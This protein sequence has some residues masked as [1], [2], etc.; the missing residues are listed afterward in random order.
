MSARLPGVVLLAIA[1]LYGW[2]AIQIPVFAADVR[3][4]MTAQTMPLVLA[5]ALAIIG[6]ILLFP[7]RPGVLLT[8]TLSADPRRWWQAAGLLAV[9]IGFGFIIEPL[10]V[11]PACVLALFAGLL[12]LGVR[13]PSI[14]V[15]V[16][17][18]VSGSMWVL[19]A[20]LLGLYLHPGD[21]WAADV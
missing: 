4:V 11:L 2:Q 12:V 16:P 10:G 17:L 8:S 1:V 21:W 6:M 19:L 15:L 20:G 5:G 14:L 13:R 3:E 9:G 7:G 18:L